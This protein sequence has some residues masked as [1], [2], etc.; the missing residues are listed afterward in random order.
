MKKDSLTEECL[1]FIVRE[2]TRVGYDNLYYNLLKSRGNGDGAA[3]FSGDDYLNHVVEE[4]NCVYE[5]ILEQQ[6]FMR[7]YYSREFDELPAERRY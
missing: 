1:G 6:K 2:V 4:S 3:S 7:S 5:L